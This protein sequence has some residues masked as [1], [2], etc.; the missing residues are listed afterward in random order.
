MYDAAVPVAL[1]A[2]DRALALLDHATPAMLAARLHPDMFSCAEQFEIT[3]GFALRATLPL[4][5]RAVT[6]QETLHDREAL[7]VHLL[8]AQSE[9]KALKP[10]DFA[11][12][13]DRRIVHRAGFADLDQSAQE[14]LQHFAIPNLW[15]HLSM[16]FAILRAEGAPVSK[17][18]FDGLHVYPP[19][20]SWVK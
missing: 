3:A 1:Q 18:D 12:V 14:Y 10:E 6:E 16:A 5:G 8:A 17:A 11:G 13:E 20:F 15:F 4:I 2:L 9:I 19:G 7:R